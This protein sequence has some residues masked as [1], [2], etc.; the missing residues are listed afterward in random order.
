MWP[1]CEWLVGGWR[2]LRCRSLAADND[3]HKVVNGRIMTATEGDIKLNHDPFSLLS[4][5]CCR[6]N[7]NERVGKY[8]TQSDKGIAFLRLI[9]DS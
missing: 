8:Y 2:C 4:L 6:L 5:R 9:W 3:V 1:H 7:N